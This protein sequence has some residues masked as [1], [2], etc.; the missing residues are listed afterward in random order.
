MSRKDGTVVSSNNECALGYLFPRY[1][2]KLPAL[3][4]AQR[5]GSG[6]LYAVKQW[7]VGRVTM[8]PIHQSCMG[9]SAFEASGT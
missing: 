8:A 2:R 3:S 6:A 5:S 4:S 7:Q 1:S 9:L